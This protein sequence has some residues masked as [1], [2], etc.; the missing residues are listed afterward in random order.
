[1]TTN[2]RTVGRYLRWVLAVLSLGAGVIHF[3]VAGEHYDLSWAHGTFFAVVAWLQ[4]SFAIA[5]VMRPTRRLL[6]AGVLLNTG[7]LGVWVMSRVWGAPF[8]SN[9]WTPE[10]IGWADGLSSAFELGIVIL[11]L[12]VLVR[13]AVAQHELRPAFARPVVGIAGLGVAVIASLAFTPAFASSHSH[14]DTQGDSA[15]VDGKNQAATA[16]HTH[17]P[18]TLNGQK[19]KGVK[20]QDVAAEGQPNQPIDAA[21]REA[22]KGQLTIA[23]DFALRYPTVGDATA[24]G[25]RLAGGFTPGSG[26]HYIG[27]GGIT[28]SGEFDPAKPISLIYDGISPTSQ[29]IGLMYYGMGQGA[30]EGFA[31]PN[32]H[33]HRHSNVCLKFGAN[34]LEVPFPA[35]TDVTEEMCQGVQGNL[36]KVTGYMVHAWVVPSWESPLGVFSHD[37]PDVRCADG[38]YNTD[39]AGFCAGT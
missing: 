7:I 9:P 20:A 17:G 35:D 23:R 21:T 31:G 2:E 26:A 36:M 39:K 8:G 12:A 13:P 10:D 1:M 37:N 27:Y 33:W 4:L 14:G 30:P 3:A 6:T 34:G 38:T 19:V 18:T 16:G 25:Y 24:A 5:V 11:A 32:D 28:G 22:L 15:A 29:V